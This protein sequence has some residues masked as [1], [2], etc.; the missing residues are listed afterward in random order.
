MFFKGTG[1]LIETLVPSKKICD[2]YIDCP[3]T[4]Q[5]EDVALQCHGRFACLTL[6]GRVNINLKE[7]CDGVLDCMDGSDED[8]ETCPDRFQCSLDNNKLV[9]VMFFWCHLYFNLPTSLFAFNEHVS[10]KHCR[11]KSLRLNHRL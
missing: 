8:T 2:G 11:V 4:Q 7:K 9:R 6:D 5:D 10:G 3:G 1:R